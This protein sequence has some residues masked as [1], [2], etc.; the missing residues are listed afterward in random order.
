[1]ATECT[2]TTRRSPILVAGVLMA[3]GAMLIGCQAN[4]AA[5]M[6]AQEAHAKQVAAWCHYSHVGGTTPSLQ[7][8]CIRHAWINVPPGECFTKP[9]IGAGHYGAPYHARFARK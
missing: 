4:S 1:M 3:S 9:C 7:E 2:S 8:Q 6:Y 5:L